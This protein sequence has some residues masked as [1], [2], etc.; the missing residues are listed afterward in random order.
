MVLVAG[1]WEC[2]QP[3]ATCSP[4]STVLPAE[5]R[6]ARTG[7]RVDA[8]EKEG[9]R[10]WGVCV[11]PCTNV[12]TRTHDVDIFLS[13]FHF[14]TVSLSLYLASKLWGSTGFSVFPFLL[15]GL[16][17]H[18]LCKPLLCTYWVKC[19]EMRWHDA[20]GEGALV[21]AHAEVPL[22]ASPHT[23]GTSHTKGPV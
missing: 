6:A 18:V 15:L 12:H 10:N 4:G 19:F 11:C 13:H 3:G 1:G 21:R 14:K 8:A 9:F 20:E 7:L 5:V 16:Q 17:V 23:P 22:P 2:S